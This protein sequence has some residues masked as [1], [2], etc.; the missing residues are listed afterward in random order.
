MRGT[1]LNDRP[2][3]ARSGRSDGWRRAAIP[4]RRTSPTA[5]VLGGPSS[6]LYA[7][8][9][10]VAARHACQRRLLL[11]QHPCLEHR[12]RTFPEG[13]EYIALGTEATRPDATGR[14]RSITR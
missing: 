6:T 12:P 9:D 11:H 2:S 5:W 14:W 7:R 3:T 8:R 4:G 13:E 10:G 1:T